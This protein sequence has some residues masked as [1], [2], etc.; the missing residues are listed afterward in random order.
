[1]ILHLEY[2]YLQMA[3]FLHCLNTKTA[4]QIYAL[5]IVREQQLANLSSILIQNSGGMEQRNYA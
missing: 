4:K 2:R 3:E 1:M 5:L